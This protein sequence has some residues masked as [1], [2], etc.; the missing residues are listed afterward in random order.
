M[1]RRLRE[2]NLDEARQE[3]ELHASKHHLPRLRH[4]DY[5]IWSAVSLAI[6]AH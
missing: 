4:R 2:C 6:P 5:L 1:K 3:E